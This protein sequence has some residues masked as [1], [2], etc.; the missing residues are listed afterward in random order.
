MGR[1]SSSGSGLGGWIA[2]FV[3]AAVVG[4]IGWALGARGGKR[5]YQRLARQIQDVIDE[6]QHR[7]REA[8]EL[9]HDR[10]DDVA[11]AIKDTSSGAQKKLRRMAKKARH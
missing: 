3:F 1:D 2:V 9:I 6:A 8:Q 4:L 10:T 5:R 11:D 7:A